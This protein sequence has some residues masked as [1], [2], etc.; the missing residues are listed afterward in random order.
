MAPKGLVLAALLVAVAVSAGQLPCG[1]AA[2]LGASPSANTSLVLSGI[3]PCA[4]GNSI[5]IA[6]VP[7]FP[8]KE[9][10]RPSSE[11]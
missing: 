11:Q 5:N 4:T 3:V 6:S 7:S 10:C 9:T 2:G 1:G 8:S